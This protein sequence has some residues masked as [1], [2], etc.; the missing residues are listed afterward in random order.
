[1]C[2]VGGR[3]DSLKRAHRM[4]L[5]GLYKTVPMRIVVPGSEGGSRLN[6]LDKKGSFDVSWK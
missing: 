5:T 2:T 4:C 1:M 3:A 6:K